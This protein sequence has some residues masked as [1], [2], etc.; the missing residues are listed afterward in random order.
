MEGYLVRP[1]HELV[2][3]FQVLDGPFWVFATLSAALKHAYLSKSWPLRPLLVSVSE[4]SILQQRADAILARSAQIRQVGTSASFFGPQGSQVM[5][6]LERLS[7]WPWFSPP[8]EGVGGGYH[9]LTSSD[10]TV[11]LQDLQQGPNALW[12]AL[13]E[14]NQAT[15]LLAQQSGL[16][17]AWAVARDYP[18]LFLADHVQKLS[19]Q[20]LGYLDEDYIYMASGALLYV[21]SSMLAQV[22]VR[23][24][25]DH[26]LL[27]Y[28]LVEL[29]SK[30]YWPLGLDQR[31]IILY[32]ATNKI[33]GR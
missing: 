17:G 32:G 13:E 25:A 5:A 24:V 21:L 19:Q 3:E 6:Y 7:T 26:N 8:T 2:Q 28:K 22:V 20:H 31:G 29:F 23:N 12:V 30:G 14:D 11:Y 15:Q 9:L 10:L 18:L 33:E 16:L 4:G 1:A 27:A